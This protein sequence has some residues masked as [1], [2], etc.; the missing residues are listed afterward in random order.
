MIRA[1]RTLLS[2]LLVALVVI[3]TS[4][5]HHVA[6]SL[7]TASVGSTVSAPWRP[8]RPPEPVT[9]LTIAPL[10]VSGRGPGSPN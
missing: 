1:L 4:G 2:Q 5:A 9:H 8:A 6:A 7:L 3:L 10:A